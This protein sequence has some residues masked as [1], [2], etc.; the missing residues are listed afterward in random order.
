MI[1]LTAF[2]PNLLRFT[3][4]WSTQLVFF[5]NSSR[6]ICPPQIFLHMCLFL[7]LPLPT[8]NNCQYL[9]ASSAQ[10]LSSWWDLVWLGLAL[11][12]CILSQLLRVFVQLPCCVQKTHLLC[13]HSLPLTLII[14]QSYFHNYLWV[15][16]RNRVINSDK[17]SP[18]S[19]RHSQALIFYS[20]FSYGFCLNH[21]PL[22]IESF[23]M[24]V[25]SCINLW[26]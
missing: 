16:G 11:V 8:A 13:V 24:R 19:T 25:E 10:L 1:T 23:P 3:L 26:E 12:L 14:F 15:L 2:S 6:S 17:Y 9:M 4:F 22:K 7:T 21:H 5:F 20:M 18:F